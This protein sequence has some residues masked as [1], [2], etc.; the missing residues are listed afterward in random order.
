MKNFG[1]NSYLYA[2]KDDHKHRALWREPYDE[3]EKA[4]LK[5]L[6]DACG[7]GGVKFFYGISPGLDITYSSD[8]DVAELKAKLDEVG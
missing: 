6:I 4:E 2:P 8:G 1:L 5:V 7:D 3:D